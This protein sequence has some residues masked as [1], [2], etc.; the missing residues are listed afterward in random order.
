ML[1]VAAAALLGVAALLQTRI[2]PLLD[3]PAIRP[4]SAIK[5]TGALGA[6]A[7][8]FEYSLAAMSGFR[9]IIAGLLWVRS[10]S[11]FHSGNYDAILPMIRLI[12][13]LDPN[14]LDPYATGAWH[15]TYNFT[16]TDQRSD[17]RY[18]PAGVAL[19]NE[20]IRNNAEI[21]DMYKEK[22]WLYY[23]KIKDYS[24]AAEAYE[25]G[26]KTKG[27][28]I[29][30]V[31]HA[32][33]HCYERQGDVEKAK[34]VWE[35]AVAGHKK[36]LDDPQST[37]ELKGRSQQGINNAAKNRE[38]VEVRDIAR[39]ADAAVPYEVN[40]RYRVKRVKP[41][42][43]E[44]AGTWNLVGAKSFD[45][46]GKRIAVQGP[47]EGARVFVVLKDEGYTMPTEE[48]VKEFTFEVD[49]KL[50]IM[51]DMLSTRGGKRVKKGEI[52]VLQE[53]LSAV[54]EQPA[55][56]AGIYPFKP[57]EAEGLGVPLEQALTNGTYFSPFALQQ[58]ATIADPLPFNSIQPIRTAAESASIL[59]RLRS[60]AALL[61]KLTDKKYF[62][63]TKDM[64]LPG[65]FKREIN[66][67][68]DPKM[69]SF[70]RDKFT[71]VLF[72]DPRHTPDFVRDRIGWKGE[73]WN[74][75]RFLV[76]EDGV[77][78]IKVEIPLTREELTGE[79]TAL[80]KESDVGMKL[81]TE[82]YKQPTVP[83]PNA[84]KSV[85]QPTATSA[86]APTDTKTGQ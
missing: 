31:W 52:F 77:R 24:R 17:R 7:L 13:W 40:F 74:D 33:A 69:Y 59:T 23:D 9:Q 35:E 58:L 10:D 83:Q 8:P 18:L 61:K 56:K 6:A 32:L 1:S 73:G 86:G 25:G 78:K 15:L 41:K 48:G 66:M 42:V 2:D 43:I 82:I 20:G 4:P 84:P 54:M 3:D 76:E 63:A 39:K 79:G 68:L 34:A 30:Q 50:T 37:P 64:E 55:E 67:S 29:T 45:Y 22:G 19:L 11:F 38:I 72:I 85:P 16:D 47:V 28:D 81:P 80:L 26:K 51:Q 12:T 65:E 60:D 71:L 14:W 27:A 36:I 49:P 53:G 46:N 75:K 44:V 57:S 21:Y 62:V 5:A 70:T